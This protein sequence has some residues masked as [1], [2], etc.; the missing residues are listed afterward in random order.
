[1]T[2]SNSS[3]FDELVEAHLR[4]TYLLA[5]RLCGRADL[6]EDIAQEAFRRATQSWH[7]FERRCSFR[8]WLF[9]IVLNVFRSQVEQK[10]TRRRELEDV[11]DPA[12]GPL[13]CARSKDFQE[14]VGRLI[15][16]LPDRQRE[17]LVLHLHQQCSHDE[18]AQILGT[19][20]QNVRTN[21]HLARK[22]MQ[23]LLEPYLRDD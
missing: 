2:G 17:V 8:T 6:A 16:T 4:E 13:C 1:M 7:K 23:E 19:S 5:L 3:D 10:G 20:I 12:S 9:R 15:G 11:P 21:L 14:Y 22:R 18:I